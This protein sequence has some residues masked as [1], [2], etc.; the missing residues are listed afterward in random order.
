MASVSPEE[1]RQKQRAEWQAAAPGWKKWEKDILTNLQP[2]SEMLIRSAGISSGF[3]VLDVATGSGEPALTI[4]RIVGPSGK[5]VGVDL[6]P[7]ML[8]TARRNASSRGI[9]NVE[10]YVVDDERLS[11]F[12]DAIFDAVVCRCGLMFM[13]EPAKALG[14]FRR[15]LKPNRKA[16][17]S[18]WGS[19]EKA[20]FL[21]L[22]MKTFPKHL[23]D[24]K[25]PAPGTPGIFAIPKVDLLRE[26]FL[27]AGFS[28]FNGQVT[29][30]FVA[31]QADDAEE[32]WQKM[33]DVLGFL[34]L[35]KPKLPNQVYMAMKDEMIA[36]T[37]SMFPNGSPRLAQ[38]L[39]IG[40]GTK[41]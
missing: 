19:P 31:I 30:D 37:R 13:P 26:L 11:R 9:T 4:A 18:V 22:M 12:Q 10:F 6:S 20:E 29:D 23:P 40:S 34:I 1:A 5:V 28:D 3:S 21:G 16:S 32:L 2:V 36:A 39:I 27:K 41:P 15:V 38:E 17:V 8:E 25:P 33:E 24:F 7:G 14:A 35:L